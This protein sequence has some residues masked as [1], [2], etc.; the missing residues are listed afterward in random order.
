MEC[1]VILR[2]TGGGHN[3]DEGGRRQQDGEG[4]E[5]ETLTLLVH[6]LW[7]KLLLS[8]QITLTQNAFPI[9]QKYTFWSML[10]NRNCPTYSDSV[11]GVLVQ[12]SGFLEKFL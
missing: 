12:T 5:G 10:H 6:D 3:R 1:E 4:E 2:F 8:T 9:T 11:P 7:P